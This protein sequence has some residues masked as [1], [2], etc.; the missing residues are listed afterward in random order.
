MDDDL[1]F[2]MRVWVIIAEFA[3]FVPGLLFLTNVIFGKLGNKT[4]LIIFFAV[5]MSTPALYTD[6]GHF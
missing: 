4:I 5:F 1:I 2:T 3:I 6:H